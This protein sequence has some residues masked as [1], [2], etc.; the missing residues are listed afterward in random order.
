MSITRRQL[1][2]GCRA[3][4]GAA[5]LGQS[6]FAQANPLN[7]GFI[8]IGPV[9]DFGW[10]TMHDR[11]RR[12]MLEVLGDRVRSTRSRPWRR[13]TSTASRRSWPAPAR[14]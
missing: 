2:A 10:S 13:P 7:V 9:G 6:A 12:R 11:G 4:A 3:M 1:M 5:A 8:L 14:G